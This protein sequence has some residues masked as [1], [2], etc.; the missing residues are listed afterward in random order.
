M[1]I[2]DSSGLQFT[3][4]FT[5]YYAWVGWWQLGGPVC[6]IER[7]N[8]VEEWRASHPLPPPHHSRGRGRGQGLG[9]CVQVIYVR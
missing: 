7:T 2:N 1:L 9:C 3:S 4:P 5:F 8:V 6:G